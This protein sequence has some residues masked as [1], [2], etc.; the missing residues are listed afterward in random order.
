MAD[1]ADNRKRIFTRRNLVIGGI[2]LLVVLV[3]VLNVFR[4]M[5]R[6]VIK[7]RTARVTE[8]KMEQTVLAS[9]RVVAVDKSVIYSQ[10]TGTVKKIQVKPGQEIQHGQLLMELD[11]PDGPQRLAQA[12][13]TLARAEA[14]LAKARASGKS[15]DLIDAEAAYAEAEAGYRLAEERLKRNQVLYREGAI[16]LETLQEIESQYTAAENRFRKAAAVLEAARASASAAL[17]GLEAAVESARASLALLETQM[18]QAGLK[19]ERSGRVLSLGVREGDMIMPNTI[20]ITVGSIDHLEIVAEI[21][22]ADALYVKT[23][24]S[25]VITSNAIPDERFIGQITGVGLETTNQVRKEAETSALPV[26]ISLPPGTPLR[27]GYNVDLEIT[28]RV[29]EKALVIPYEAL[30]EIDDEPCVYVVRDNVAH[31]Q[32]VETGM[33][34]NFNIQVKS[35][36]KKGDTVVLESPQD[37]KE[38]SRVKIL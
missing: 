31:L 35:G 30:I 18:G 37:L 9:G 26:T 4:V 32:K 6:D 16:S 25:A 13:A 7:V 1:S 24:Q 29:E 10:V 21:N 2:L 14:D 15:L 20:L 11:I 12:R 5:N 33:Y 28:T 38:G 23:G 8:Q 3:V 36:L 19:A 34:D 17:Q 27:P 22:E